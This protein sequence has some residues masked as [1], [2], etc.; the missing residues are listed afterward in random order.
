MAAA[1]ANVRVKSVAERF[2]N[3]KSLM[4]YPSMTLK[5]SAH[6]MAGEP[7]K[8]WSGRTMTTASELDD[9]CC[10]V[11]LKAQCLMGIHK[12]GWE[13]K[14]TEQETMIWKYM[15]NECKWAGNI[16]GENG[17]EVRYA[18][19]NDRQRKALI[20]DATSGGSYAIPD[21]FDDMVWR[22]P[23]LY[24]ELFPYVD[25][26]NLPRGSSVDGLTAGD[27]SV[28]WSQAEGSTYSL[29]STSGLVSN[30]DATIFPMMLAIEMGLD[31]LSDTPI[32][33]VRDWQTRFGE[34]AM[35]QLDYCVA[36]GDGTTQPEGIFTKSG[37]TSVSSGS[38]TDGPYIVGDF[39]SL[40]FGLGKAML[41]A[42]GGKIRW[43]TSDTNYR[44]ACSVP[45]GT[46]DERRVMQPA[47]QHARYMFWDYPVGIQG[48]VANGA[49]ALAN[50][51]YYRMYRRLG[52]T[53]RT[54]MEGATLHK[55]NS[56]LLTMRSRWGG[57]L[58]IASAVAKITD[59]DQTDG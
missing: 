58:A 14:L 52:T 16:G 59:G 38:G 50:L 12:I 54:T 22:T 3:S 49:I 48:D 27:L 9:A 5:Q 57:Q 20:D 7:V 30:L 39:E 34:V 4:T 47:L 17:E 46:T 25:L 15:L 53:F 31:F 28:T 13:G 6:P 40:I 18:Y 35:A 42:R 8:S 10:A 1:G 55:N 51:G 23:L 2:N 45:V 44:R 21:A 56:M 32:D 36:V 37:T 43:V 33:W 11:F 19:L 29:P 24:G 41:S 26:M